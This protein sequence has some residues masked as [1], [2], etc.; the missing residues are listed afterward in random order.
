MIHWENWAYLYSLEMIISIFFLLQPEWKLT[1]SGVLS[2]IHIG[3]SSVLRQN[4]R[5]LN[6]DTV[7]VT[8]I[9]DIALKMTSEVSL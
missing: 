6:M 4:S 3:K 7:L 8:K 2:G 9:L 1:Y 5:L